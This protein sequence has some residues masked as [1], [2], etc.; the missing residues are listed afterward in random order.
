MHFKY[1]P[2][3]ASLENYNYNV[4]ISAFNLDGVEPN[5]I[6]YYLHS[7]MDIHHVTRKIDS[8]K[9]IKIFIKHNHNSR[10][11]KYK[12]FP[13]TDHEAYR[14]AVTWGLLNYNKE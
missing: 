10:L 4:E 14:N 8:V 5:I 13:G 6:R 2:D 3:P 9:G 7:R 12:F 1:T 11:H